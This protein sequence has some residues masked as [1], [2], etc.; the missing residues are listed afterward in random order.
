MQALHNLVIAVWWCHK[1]LI[2][3]AIYE[4]NQFYEETQ[5]A[6]FSVSIAS[7][8]SLD[9]HASNANVLIPFVI[10]LI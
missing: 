6:P 4:E 5:I 9:A 2:Y 10:K 8:N 1:C 3:Q 7:L